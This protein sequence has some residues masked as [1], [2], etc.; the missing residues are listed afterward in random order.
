MIISYHII[1]YHIISYHIISYHIISYHIISYVWC[2]KLRGPKAELNHILEFVIAVGHSPYSIYPIPSLISSHFISS[3]LNTKIR[4][5]QWLFAS[6]APR[7][8]C[9]SW[10]CSHRAERSE[11]SHGHCTVLFTA[12]QRVKKEMLDVT[13]CNLTYIVYVVISAK[14]QKQ[15]TKHPFKLSDPKNCQEWFDP[16]K[17]SDHRSS[18]AC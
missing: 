13:V 10:C 6:S 5:A 2:P 12:L 1:S 7:S 9:T 11:S 8:S 15:C 16:G 4:D 14:H 17:R 3:H 18:A